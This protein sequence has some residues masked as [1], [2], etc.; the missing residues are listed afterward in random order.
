MTQLFCFIMST[1][2]CKHRGKGWCYGRK[3]D[4]KHI[5]RTWRTNHL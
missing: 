1:T 5:T 2:D 3:Q 4:K